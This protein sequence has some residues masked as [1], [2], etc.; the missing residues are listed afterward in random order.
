MHYHEVIVTHNNGFI[1]VKCHIFNIKEYLL[2]NCL[3]LTLPTAK[4]CP[5]L[6]KLKEIIKY[7]FFF[8]Q[9]ITTYID[10]VSESH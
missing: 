2:T 3:S 1:F 9:R 8:K 10:C 7:I 6:I 4:T 5:H